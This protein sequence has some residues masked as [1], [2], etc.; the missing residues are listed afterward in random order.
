[1]SRADAP[2]SNARLRPALAPALTAVVGACVSLLAFLFAQ[3]IVDKLVE[4]SALRQARQDVSHIEAE[5]ERL[6]LAA[7]AADAAKA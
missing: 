5:F 6:A 4:E 1:M 7:R 2:K 3:A